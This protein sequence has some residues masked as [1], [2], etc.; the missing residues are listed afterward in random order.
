DALAT[1]LLHRR[2][3]DEIVPDHVARRQPLRLSREQDPGPGRVLAAGRPAERVGEALEPA[4]A[5][6]QRLD[7][8]RLLGPERSRRVEGLGLRD[9][10]LLLLR[11]SRELGIE[12]A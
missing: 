7:D 9:V 5:E 8:A 1:Q 12:V 6:L 3:L 11:E 2:R 4:D 10:L